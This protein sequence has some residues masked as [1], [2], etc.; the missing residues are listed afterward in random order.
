[1]R[2]HLGTAIPPAVEC[3]VRIYEEVNK[4]K[5]TFGQFAP[6]QAG[7]AVRTPGVSLLRLDWDVRSVIQGLGRG[8]LVDT[9]DRTVRYFRT[10]PGDENSE[11]IESTAFIYSALL[12][13]D[14]RKTLSEVT[15][16]LAAR[17]VGPNSVPGSAIMFLIEK[18]CGKGLIQTYKGLSSVENFVDTQT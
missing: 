1:V 10:T 4:V 14:G 11:L 18:L 8:E 3:L 16:E 17:I 15:E 12:L 2:D 13:C 5:E 7:C 9:I 6:P